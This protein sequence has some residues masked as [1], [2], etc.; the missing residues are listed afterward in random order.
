VPPVVSLTF[1]NGP[2]AGVTERVLDILSTRHVTATFF[3][4]GTELADP[5]G[6][7]ASKRAVAEGHRVGG[8]TWS[9]T[10][11]FGQADDALVDSELARTS[12][13]VA[14]VGGD[15]LLFRPYGVGG[16]TDERLMSRH[17]ADRLRA[18]GYTC[19]LWN[20]LPGD[21]LDADG[22]VDQAVDDVMAQP[23]TV[24]VLHDLPVGAAD[25]LDGFLDRL[26]ALGVEFSLDSPDECTPIRAGVPTSSF[27]VLGVGD[28]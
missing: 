15:P 19:V 14:A 7:Q 13:A 2:T 28:P 1:D 9:H 26:A 4:V 11:P 8:H 27:A 21:W 3:V 18:G 17:G 16:V 20:S 25:R 10:I 24:V 23:W 6:R 22:W 12:E 5:A